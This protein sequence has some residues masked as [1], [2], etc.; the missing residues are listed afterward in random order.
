MRANPL[1]TKQPLELINIALRLHVLYCRITAILT[2]ARDVR[3]TR[4]SMGRTGKATG[5][6]WQ[7]GETAACQRQWIEPSDRD[8]PGRIYLLVVLGEPPERIHL[9]L[10]V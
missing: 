6:E 4:L 7:R 5:S 8:R 9:H 10:E 3:R 2:S 1:P